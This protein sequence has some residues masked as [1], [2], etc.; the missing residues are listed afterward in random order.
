MLSAA[1]PGTVAV[2]S[3]MAI[4]TRLLVFILRQASHDR[5]TNGSEKRV[6]GLLAQEQSGCSTGQS[7]S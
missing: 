1:A 7:S 3:V 4:V 6:S 2:L 5:T